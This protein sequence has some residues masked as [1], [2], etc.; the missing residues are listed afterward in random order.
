MEI[1]DVVNHTPQVAASELVK[2]TF[3]ITGIDVPFEFP[4]SNESL[5][6]PMIQFLEN[7]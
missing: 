5:T 3:A 6:A 2:V 7:T 1:V 4:F